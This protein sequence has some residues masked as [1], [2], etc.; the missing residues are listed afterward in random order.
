[1]YSLQIQGICPGESYCY[2][3]YTNGNTV[4]SIFPGSQ[5]L[6][7]D[8][9]ITKPIRISIYIYISFNIHEMYINAT[10]FKSYFQTKFIK[11]NVWNTFSIN[12]T[13]YILIICVTET[14]HFCMWS[15]PWRS[16]WQWYFVFSNPSSYL[17]TGM[18]LCS[19][20]TRWCVK[21]FACSQKY[22][23][24]PIPPTNTQVLT[25]ETCWMDRFIKGVILP[26]QLDLI[27][28]QLFPAIFPLY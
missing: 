2:T 9:I 5:P 20:I 23:I 14:N 27:L 17:C 7:Q 24:L 13:I 1:M 3:V 4:D 22:H 12:L 8:Q 11:A 19:H 16:I 25:F 6:P 21:N 10:F 15:K 28:L 18:F 26:M